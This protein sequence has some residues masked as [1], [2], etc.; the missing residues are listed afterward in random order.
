LALA[1]AANPFRPD[2]PFAAPFFTMLDPPPRQCQR[3][4]LLWHAGKLRR[5]TVGPED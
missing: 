1:H 5:L 3:L 4:A 2:Q